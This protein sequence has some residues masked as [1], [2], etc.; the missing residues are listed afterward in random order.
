[1][2]LVLTSIFFLFDMII[3][4]L[5][6]SLEYDLEDIPT[7][8]EVELFQPRPGVYRPVVLIGRSF[9]SSMPPRNIIMFSLTV[10]CVGLNKS[11]YVIRLRLTS[12]FVYSKTFKSFGKLARFN[13]TYLL[14]PSYI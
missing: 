5:F 2:L 12:F 9:C 8:E 7:Y 13:D 4:M 11:I 6:F 3:V 1:M 14:R 10:W